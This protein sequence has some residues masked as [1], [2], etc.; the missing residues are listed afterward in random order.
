MVRSRS[1]VAGQ[2]SLGVYKSSNQAGSWASA[3][4]GL[5]SNFPW[6][7]LAA[8]PSNAV[9]ITDFF[10]LYETTN[11]GASWNLNGSL[12]TAFV[13]CIANTLGVSGVNPAVVYW[14]PCYFGWAIAPLAVS[15]PTQAR[16]GVPRVDWALPGSTRFLVIR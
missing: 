5:Y 16:P 7:D 4:T 15:L 8:G 1:A 2:D 9:Y 13:G 11:G 6:G 14:A 12:P 10:S 3:N